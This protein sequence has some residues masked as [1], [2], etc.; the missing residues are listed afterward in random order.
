MQKITDLSQLDL[1]KQ[2]TY[3]DYLTW[4]FNER[5]ELIKGW[6]YKMSPAPKRIHQKVEGIIFN[7][8]FNFL[9]F[10]KCEIYQSPFDVRLL[11]NKD[12]E[13]D[14][15]YTV[16]QPDICVVCDEDKLDDAGCVGAPDLIVEV[17][18]DSTAKKD[19]NEKFNLY[20][21]NAVKEYWIVNPATQT[22]EIF[23]LEN[24]T[25]TSLGLFNENEG[26]KY[27]VGQLFPDLKIELK[28][29]FS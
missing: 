5:V 16:V 8:L 28:T 6:L 7:K 11:K 19:Y 25:Y 3:A 15:I 29:I 2:Y 21:E 1:N 9:E 12:D 10:S 18:S 14:K 26:E 27:V 23:T 13:N 22:I 20:E 17:L 24:Q 4:H